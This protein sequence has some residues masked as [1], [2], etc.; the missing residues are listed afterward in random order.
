V[1]G[2]FSAV[3]LLIAGMIIG[4]IFTGEVV[5]ILVRS[6]ERRG[7]IALKPPGLRLEDH[8]VVL[9]RNEHLEGLLSQLYKAYGQNHY[10]LVV[11]EDAETIPSPCPDSKDRLFALEGNPSRSNILEAAN[12]ENARRVVILSSG[13]ANST[14]REKDNMA[15]MHALATIGKNKNVP[16]VVE[17][18]ESESLVY[19]KT[20]G[21]T[22]CIVSRFFGEKLMS[23]AI[24][25]PGIT[26][27]YDELMTVDR[28]HNELYRVSTPPHL[29]GK[30]F[31]QAQAFF[32][33]YDEAAILLIGV[34][35]ANARAYHGFRLGIP[36]ET[37]SVP[38]ANHI[39]SPDDRLLICA[40]E[41]PSFD[42]L[43]PEKA[44]QNDPNSMA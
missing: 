39:L 4:A 41:R 6:E 25:H 21:N 11:C 20:L 38:I 29:V 19:A 10:L 27:I 44:W 22:D 16:M 3:G 36:D 9:G 12:I 32:L 7:R 23:Q 26:E 2:K 42:T 8:V 1:A 33:D 34:E 24:L 28:K 31:R 13:N 5:A 14:A 43:Q 18:Q 30:T 37:G 40:L 35:S 15:L 17:L